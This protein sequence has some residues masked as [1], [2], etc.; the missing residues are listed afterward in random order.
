MQEKIPVRKIKDYGVNIMTSNVSAEKKPAAK[1]G[2]VLQIVLSLLIFAGFAV[3]LFVPD[4]AAYETSLFT[5]ILNTFK[6]EFIGSDFTKFAMYAAT[7]MYAVLLVCTIVSLFTCRKAAAALNFVKTIVAVAVTAFLACALIRE[8]DLTASDIFYDPKTYLALNSV[9][10]S[11]VLGLVALAVLSIATYKGKGVVKLF[12]ALLAAGFFVFPYYTFIDAYTFADLFGSV[13]LGSGLLATITTYVF[14][15]L[16]WAALANLALAVLAFA[17]RRTSTFDLIRSCIMLVLAVAAGV[18]FGVR[19]S[20]G[21]LFKTIGL[22]GITGVALAQ[23][24]FWLIVVCV[25]HARRKKSAAEKESAQNAFVFDENNQMTFAGLAGQP[26]AAEAQPSDT[27]A[28]AETA[29]PDAAPA[30]DAQ[31]AEEVNPDAETANKA[32]ED[33]AQIS[34]D[35]IAQAQ[36]DDSSY[37]SAIRDEAEPVHEQEEEKPFDFNQAKYD[38]KFNRQYADFAAEQERAE[39][40]AQPQPDYTAQQPYQAAPPYYGNAYQQPYAQPGPANYYNAGF[41]PDGFISSLTPAEK[42]EFDRLF[43]SRVYGDNKRLP[44]YRIGGDNR[45]FFTKIFVFMGRYRNVISDGL[46]EKIYNYSNSIR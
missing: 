37:N 26:A 40:A 24:I 15:I 17:V 19:S 7:G 36:Q 18:L 1:Q 16:A 14:R 8:F 21:E 28:T 20:F 39:Q 45:E 46:L 11:M 33:A 43:I 25:L 22:I 12:G 13:T 29:A 4:L 9:S 32:F 2:R 23:F 5:Q 38:G 44:A 27:A 35:E 41:I 34:F 6:N 42:D 3:F 30:A 31:P 10:L